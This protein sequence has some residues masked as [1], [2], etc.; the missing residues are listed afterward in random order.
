MKLDR[1]RPFG[2]ICGGAPV[3]G[4]R[5]EQGGKYFNG[6]GELIEWPPKEPEKKKEDEKSAFTY[7]TPVIRRKKATKK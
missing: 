3:S 5:F 4:A 1:T 2:T 6:A 7:V